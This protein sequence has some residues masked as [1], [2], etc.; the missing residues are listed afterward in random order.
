MQA[1]AELKVNAFVIGGFVRDL[2]LERPSKDIDIVVE[3]SGIE[4]A[5]RTVFEKFGVNLELEIEVIG[6]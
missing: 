1:A 5:Q 4:L 2:Y 6:E 3:G